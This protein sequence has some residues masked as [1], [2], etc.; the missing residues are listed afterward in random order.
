MTP[1][2]LRSRPFHYRR[3]QVLIALAIGLLLATL[4]WVSTEQLRRHQEPANR[5]EAGETAETIELR[6]GHNTPEDS[7]LHQAALRFARAVEQKTDQ[8]VQIKVFPAQQLGNDHEMV[9]MAREGRLDILLTPTAKLSLPLPAMQYADLP[10][11]FPSRADVYRLL[12]GAPGRMLLDRLD[13]IGLIGV[14]FWENGFKHFTGNQPFLTPADFVGKSIRVMK[15]RIIMDQFR[16]L[17]AEPVPIDFHATRQALAEGAVDGQEN[18]LVAIV[19]MGFHE[20]QSDLV[21][22]EHAYLGYVFSI[23]QRSYDALP[24]PVRRAL[25]DTALEITPWER[26]ETRRREQAL[27]ERVRAAGVRIHQLTPKQR[28]AFADKVSWIAKASEPVIGT[29]IISKT[30]EILLERYG[31]APEA[32]AQVLIGLNADLSVDGSTT[33]LAIKRGIELAIAEINAAGGLLGKPVRLLARDHRVTASIGLDNLAHFID[34]EDLVA[35][36]GGKYSAVIAEEAPRAQEAGM[37]Y[38]IPWATMPEL[39]EPRAADNFLFRISAND[40]FVSDFL[41]EQLL[42]GHQRPALVVENSVWGRSNQGRMSQ[43]LEQLGFASGPSLRVN[44]G[45]TDFAKELSEMTQAQ[46]DSVLMVL[47]S[48]EAAHFLRQMA[49][50][51]KPLP[52]VSHWGIIGGDFFAQ[53]QDVLPGLDLRFFQTYLADDPRHPRRQSLMAAYREAYAWPDDQAVEAPMA[54]AQA[55]DLTQLLAMAVRQAGTTDRARVRDALEQLPSYSG[56][57]KHYNRPFSPE[58]HDP[59]GTEDYFL[60]RF[61]RDGRIVPAAD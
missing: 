53:L 39:T 37:P 22:S 48:R 27:L 51:P 31:P 29:D 59:L 6:F 17:G 47:N 12:D 9:E 16:A 13:R 19:S 58:D 57:I 8:R 23:S 56:A 54:V 52:V 25:V 26:Q 10:F 2:S 46:S 50:M 32:R 43:R 45:Q 15:S 55:Y 28:Q 7:A 33:G 49:Q 30:E 4:L 61:D 44:R 42:E 18:P 34:R 1:D 36:I 41:V 14:T 21:L 35:V 24:Q 11:F 60:A 40:R 20:V 38:L 5:P 3:V